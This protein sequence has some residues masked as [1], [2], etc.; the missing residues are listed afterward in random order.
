MDRELSS[1]TLRQR[2]IRTYLTGLVGVAIITSGFLFFRSS[3]KTSISANKIRT[4]TA[5]LGPI[6]NTLTASGVLIPEFEQVISS[7]IKAEI[8]RVIVTPGTTVKIDQP[9][10]ELDKSQTIN[11]Y[12]KQKD[13]LDLKRN[14]ITQL[15]IKLQKSL[16]ELEVDNAIKD[17]N[18]GS[19]QAKL[20]NTQHLKTV[21]GAT[22][23]EV[24]EADFNLKTAELE[25]KKLANELKT[26]KQSVTTDLREMELQASIQEKDLRELETKLK[27]ADITAKRNGVVTWVNENIGSSVSEGE[28]LAKIADLNGYSIEGSCSDTYSEMLRPG[29]SVIVKINEI[30]LRGS[31]TNIRP[32]IKNNILTFIVALEKNNHPALRPNMKVE[33]FIV[34]N[35]SSQVVRIANGPAFSGKAEQSVFVL[36]NGVA[37]RR[38]V[39][40]G[41]SNFDFVELKNNIKPG[42]TIIISDMSEYEHL[43]DISI[44]K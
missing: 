34:T 24:N 5:E 31:I 37:H 12:E 26:M 11:D 43:N 9:I 14:A 10:L 16:Y 25:K 29:M 19:L 28:E 33:V 7:P 17:L 42:E 4:A 23:E 3:L 41:A 13:Q 30:I 35:A 20:N 38:Q 1:Q 8:K 32:T 21:G 15:R 44:T 22:Q 39:K 40:I 2:K 36:E 27:Q 6:E 18:I